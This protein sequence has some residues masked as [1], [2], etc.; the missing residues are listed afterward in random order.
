MGSSAGENRERLALVHAGC[1]S[2]MQ[3]AVER[4]DSRG[5]E[6]PLPIKGSGGRLLADS[7]E[8]N[9]RITCRKAWLAPADAN[10]GGQVIPNPAL[11]ET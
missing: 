11:P 2:G 1:S 10:T 3:R 8:A 4:S 9:L 7:A 6:D 5:F